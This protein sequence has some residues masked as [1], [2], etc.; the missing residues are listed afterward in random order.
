MSSDSMTHAAAVGCDASG[1][2]SVEAQNPADNTTFQV[3]FHGASAEK[4]TFTVL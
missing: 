4:G 2:P 1:P 3:I